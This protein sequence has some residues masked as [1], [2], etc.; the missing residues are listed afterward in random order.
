MTIGIYCLVFSNGQRYVGQS[1]SI[2]RRIGEHME[3]MQGVHKNKKIRRAVYECGLPTWEILEVCA[4]EDL[5]NAEIKWVRYYD[6][7][8]NGLNMTIGG[9]YARKGVSRNPS[10][11]APVDVPPA[12][13]PWPVYVLIGFIVGAGVFLALGAQFLLL[14]FAIFTAYLCLR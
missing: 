1:N 4:L 11:V 8:C 13:S 14:F 12:A 6:S 2:E 3:D 9:G 7:Y 5:N 10:V